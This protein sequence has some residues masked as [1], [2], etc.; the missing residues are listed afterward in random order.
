MVENPAQKPKD[1]QE[2]R[3]LPVFPTRNPKDKV[4][5]KNKRK[6]WKIKTALEDISMPLKTIL[7]WSGFLSTI[8][9]ANNKR[10]AQNINQKVPI[11]RMMPKKDSPRASEKRAEKKST[12]TTTRLETK[13]SDFG[14]TIFPSENLAAIQKIIDTTSPTTKSNPLETSRGILVKGKKKTGNNTI[15]MKRAQN[16]ILSKI[17][18]RIIYLYYI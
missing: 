3:M 6:T 7:A 8:E 11:L 9:E 5:E 1:T 16:E 4:S 18:D 14:K 10:K 12:T 17:F 15:T 2:P 13:T